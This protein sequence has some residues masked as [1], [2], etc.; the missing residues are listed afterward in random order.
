ME[1]I[2]RLFSTLALKG[3]VA[4]L[5]GQYERATGTKIEAEFAPTL[6]LLKRLRAGEAVQQISELKQVEEI[7][8]VGPIPLSLQTPAV[9]AGGRITASMQAAQAD[10]LLRFLGSPDVLPVLRA[11]GLE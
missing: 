8:V 10:A 7:E 4:R 5:A 11:S 3:A 6:S 1:N 2:V 9:F